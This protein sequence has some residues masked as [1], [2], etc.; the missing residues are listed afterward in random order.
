MQERISAVGR[1]ATTV[2]TT[3][4]GN[5]KAS[6]LLMP[7]QGANIA[8]P[9]PAP[10]IHNLTA[11]E[12][13][14]FLHLV[15]SC[16]HITTHYEL[17]LLAR[18]ALQFFLPHDILI[19]AWGDF[20]AHDPQFDVISNIPGMRTNRVCNKLVLLAKRLHKI[21]INGG[22]Q[23]IVLNK[24]VREQRACA[25]DACTRPCALLDMRLTVAHGIRNKRDGCDSL[26]IALRPSP[27]AK[28]GAETRSRYLADAVIHQIDVAYR[29]V[30]ALHT[31]TAPFDERPPSNLLSVLSA[32]EEEITNWVCQGKTNG[33]IAQILSISVNT[34]KNH[35]HRI[36]DKLG[37]DNRTHAVVKYRDAAGRAESNL[38]GAVQ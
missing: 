24:G 31:A 11:E 5:G 35:V 3:V 2:G 16:G 1:T 13:A 9:Q 18:G 28:N 7:S 6:K 22:S 23:P 37:A 21:W 14:R 33:Q 29:K 38:A 4:S 15:A 8:S 26:Y 27:F 17:F 32:R 10:G 30:A 36:F 34:V 19:A 25:D 20:R 12:N